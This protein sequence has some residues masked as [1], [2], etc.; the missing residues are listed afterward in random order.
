MIASLGIIFLDFSIRYLRTILIHVGCIKS[1]SQQLLSSTRSRLL[2][3]LLELGFEAAQ[4][5][6]QYFND[7]KGRVVRLDFA[8]NSQA[9]RAGQHFYCASR[10][11]PSGRAILSP[12]LRL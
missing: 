11:S 4:A 9:W 3:P 7:P 8:H 2:T 6:L 10:L 12:L 1:G 5:K